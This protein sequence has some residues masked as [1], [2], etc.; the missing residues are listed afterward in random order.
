M[1]FQIA[2]KA[3]QDLA[4]Q[5]PYFLKLEGDTKR[6]KQYAQ[7]ETVLAKLHTSE[8][9][10]VFQIDRVSTGQKFCVFETHFNSAD[11]ARLSH[12][13]NEVEMMHTIRYT[14]LT[15]A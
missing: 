11:H 15:R 8:D 14:P 4:A 7:N 3:M 10:V 9:P 6:S 5:E 12:W 13:L 1:I 2:L